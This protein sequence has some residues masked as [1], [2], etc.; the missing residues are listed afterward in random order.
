MLAAVASVE[1][2]AGIGAMIVHTAAARGAD[3]EALC[4]ATGF[5]LKAAYDPDARIALELLVHD[6]AV[7][8]LRDVPGGLR[9]EHAFRIAGAVQ[10]RHSA[11][12]TIASVLIVGSQM[13]G[14]ALP[15]LDVAFRH[16]RPSSER[17]NAELLRCF[18]R[19]PTFAQP[20]NAITLA[21]SDVDVPV[22]SAD[23]LLSRVVERHAEDLLKKLPQ[24][25][26]TAT[27]RVQRMLSRALGEGD[28]TLAAIARR[29]HMS[30]RSVQRKL[31]EEGTSFD[32]LL[33][34]MRRDLA[35]RYLADPKIGIAE[36]AFLLGYSEPS[37][38]H[39][40]FKRWTGS[41]PSEARRTQQAQA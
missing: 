19:A 35:T 20:M 14:A 38:F 2:A 34:A 9:V 21:A 15:A 7:F 8:T 1:M 12:F 32:T 18:G 10:S 26:E 40:A 41:T 22:P 6:A 11:E 5:D 23:P 24:L 25:E 17:A 28:V 37:P 16:A 36:V 30:E 31:A 13:R 27:D 39:R 29:L 33:D 4:R 3:P